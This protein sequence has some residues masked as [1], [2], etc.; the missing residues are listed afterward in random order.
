MFGSILNIVPSKGLGIAVL[1]ARARP[2][3]PPIDLKMLKLTFHDCIGAAAGVC[4]PASGGS[5]CLFAAAG[6]ALV[7][8]RETRILQ[9]IEARRVGAESSSGSISN[10]PA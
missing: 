2:A 5:Q 6:F 1:A 8:V 7:S 10:S 9:L 4:H 3:D